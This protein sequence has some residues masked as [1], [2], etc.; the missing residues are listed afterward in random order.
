MV[1]LLMYPV[2]AFTQPSAMHVRRHFMPALTIQPCGD[3]RT[4]P[5]RGLAAPLC[6]RCCRK[7]M[8]DPM[9]VKS[10][11]L[12]A[13][14]RMLGAA[15]RRDASIGACNHSC[16]GDQRKHMASLSYC[17]ADSRTNH[18]KDYFRPW[19]NVMSLHAHGRSRARTR[20]VPQEQRGRYW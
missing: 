4:W 11:L 12:R 6:A 2:A 5:W 7:K 1:M 3:E 10:S 14:S 16:L 13:C 19:K 15:C 18:C 8:Q 9:M 20:S 17:M